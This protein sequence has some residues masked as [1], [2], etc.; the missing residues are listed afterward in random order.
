MGRFKLICKSPTDIE[1]A[2]NGQKVQGV[3]NMRLDMDANGIPNLQMGF[4]ILDADIYLQD[5][6]LKANITNNVPP[7]LKQL[8]TPIIEKYYNEGMNKIINN[9]CPNCGSELQSN[10]YQKPKGSFD[11]YNYCEECNWDDIRED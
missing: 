1:I 11:Y 5:V 3:T 6:K 2:L 9:K 10:E 8:L 7:V 4:E